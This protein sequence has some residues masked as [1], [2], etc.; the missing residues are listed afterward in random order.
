MSTWPVLTL[1]GARRRDA[2]LAQALEDGSRDFFE[3]PSGNVSLEAEL[4]PVTGGRELMLI[5][6]QPVSRA[7][8]AIFI[9]TINQ[10]ANERHG[11][12]SRPYF[13]VNPQEA[14]PGPMV[15]VVDLGNASGEDRRAGAELA[16]VAVGTAEA[17][18]PQG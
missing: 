8:H 9:K 14:R 10:V 6:S 15:V 18:S 13:R 4:K 16:S 2:A 12:F 7:W 5:G 11:H 1:D 3:P 17:L